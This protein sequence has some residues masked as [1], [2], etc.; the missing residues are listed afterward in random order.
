[1]D[2]VFPYNCTDVA[3]PKMSSEYF[4][5]LTQEEKEKAWKDWCERCM[6][7]VKDKKETEEYYKKRIEELITPQLCCLVDKPTLDPYD[8]HLCQRII[9]NI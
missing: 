3:P 2:R 5:T 6:K 9:D 7:I 8:D 1:M 4:N